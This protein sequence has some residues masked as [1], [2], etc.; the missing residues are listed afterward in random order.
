MTDASHLQFLITRRATDRARCDAAFA[1]ADAIWDKIA[2]LNARVARG[3][4]YTGEHPDDR[5]AKVLLA[6]LRKE[7][8]E[9]V[10]D[11]DDAL[12][13]FRRLED[14]YLASVTECRMYGIEE[15]Q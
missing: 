10:T 6:D 11:Y 8:R 15:E 7:R 3:V 9:L 14:V 5:K 1:A 12:A 2:A 13:K 4:A